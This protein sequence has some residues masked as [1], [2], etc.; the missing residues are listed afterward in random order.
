MTGTAPA[1]AQVPAEPKIW[2]VLASAG[3]AMTSGNTDTSTINLAYDIAYDPQTRN[4]IR[5][6]ALWLRGEIDGTLAASRLGLTIRDEYEINTRT[7][8]FGQNQYLRDQFKTIDYLLAPTGGIGY[9]LFDTDRTKMAVDG[10]LGGVWEKNPA[11]DTRASGAVVIGEKVT[12]L[13]TAT[14]TLTQSFSGL[15]KTKDVEDTLFTFGI[16]VAASMSERMQLKVEL[17]DAFKNKPPVA[18]VQKN[19]VAMLMAIVYKM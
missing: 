15:W 2:T 13:L 19:D 16:A 12:Q 1:S 18:S 9:R 14:T 11:A 5:S 7:F 10:A 17:L 8:V 3:V 6:E 4:V